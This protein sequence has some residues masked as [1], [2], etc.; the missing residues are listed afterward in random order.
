MGR[1]RGGGGR[2]TVLPPP[3]EKKTFAN[4]QVQVQG[5]LHDMH[6]KVDCYWCVW[7]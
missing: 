4:V 3:Q 1:G 2:D 7:V 6:I 5:A